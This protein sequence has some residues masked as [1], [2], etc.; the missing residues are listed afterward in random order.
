[1]TAPADR[2]AALHE[3]AFPGGGW[4]AQGIDDLAT[5]AGGFLLVEEDGFA[6]GRAVAG[7]AEL[8]MLA[9][10]PDARRRGV[11]RRLL[12]AFAAEAAARGASELHLEVGET[13]AAARAL[14]AAEGWSES[15][16]RRGYYRDRLGNR[17]DA[18]LMR[19]MLI[20]R[21]ASAY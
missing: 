19:R 6:L 18:I 4:S 7:E 20:G 14:Y 3:A 11:G 9:V 15:G 1:M 2:A 5:A 17:E 21:A 8:L 16:R 10:H 12:A 13:N